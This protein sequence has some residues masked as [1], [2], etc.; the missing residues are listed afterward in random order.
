MTPNDADWIYFA[1][2]PGL[3]N[4]TFVT[5]KRPVVFGAA[6]AI[7]SGTLKLAAIKHPSSSVYPPGKL[8]KADQVS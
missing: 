7:A 6:V 5:I 1:Y 2:A 4:A 3:A 8:V